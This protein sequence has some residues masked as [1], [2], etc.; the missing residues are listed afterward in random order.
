MIG[1]IKSC[2]LF[3]M[4]LIRSLFIALI[5]L[6]SFSAHSNNFAG[7][8]LDE[9]FY[10]DYLH[11]SESQ[12]RNPEWMRLISDVTDI[13]EIAIPG[14]HNALSL[15]GGDVVQNQTM[16]TA[17]M[18]LSGIRFFDTRFKYVSRKNDLVAFHGPIDQYRLFSEFIADVSHFLSQYPT[19]LVIIRVQNEAGAEVDQNKFWEIFNYVRNKHIAY[20]YVPPRNTVTMG[21]A[22]GKFVFVRDFNAAQRIG[23]ERSSFFIQDDYKLA[24]NW[25]LYSKWD[26]IKAHFEALRNNPT[27]SLNY[28][29]G[30]VGALP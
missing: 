12:Y 16:T 8:I 29:S 4:K 28:L 23:I 2:R 22:R 6:L 9:G 26:K 20:N 19:E 21:E 7:Q 3:N 24:N 15:H 10:V 13:K 30:A 25:A 27:L 18:L 17:E 1:N 11:N 5:A 14:V